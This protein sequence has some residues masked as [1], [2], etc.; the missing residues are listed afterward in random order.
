MSRVEHELL[1]L[2]EDDGVDAVGLNVGVIHALWTLHGLAP[3]RG[4]PETIAPL[5]RLATK[6][7]SAAVRR[8]AIQVMPVKE[9][10]TLLKQWCR[11]LLLFARFRRSCP[12]GCFCSRLQNLK[13]SLEQDE[14]SRIS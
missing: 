12:N 14:R 6:H 5:S 2:L 11:E 1:E 8:I 3:T 13:A 4:L 9:L 10:P 7:P